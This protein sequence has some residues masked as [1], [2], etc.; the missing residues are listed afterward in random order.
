MY[1]DD[2][3]DD[4]FY[5]GDPRRCPVHGCATS[6]PDGMFDAPCPECEFAMDEDF[7][8][9]QDVSEAPAVRSA[10]PL[11]E[12]RAVFVQDDDIPF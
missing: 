12:D 2:D 1:Y 7:H 4:F 8:A 5:S 9:S 3:R 11:R 6:S 10:V